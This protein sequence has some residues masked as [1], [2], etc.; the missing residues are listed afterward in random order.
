MSDPSPAPAALAC[1]SCRAPMTT[2]RLDGHYGTGVDL[3][4]CQICHGIWFDERESLRLT[5]GATLRL[6]QT[7][8]DGR[9]AKRRTLA[10]RLQCP[11]CDLRLL[12]THDRQRATPFRYW[13]CARAHGRFITFFDFLREKEFVRPLTA[14][15]IA[16]LRSQ[17]RS[18]NCSNC[19]GPI[20]LQTASA[21]SYCR[22]PLSMLD[23]VQVERMVAA[24]GEAEAKRVA[25]ERLGPVD[26]GLPLALLRERLHVERL[27]R[28]ADHKA[29]WGLWSPNGL[30]EAGIGAV[31]ELLRRK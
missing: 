9:G 24:L 25:A 8:H 15:Q 2:L 31:V 26:P 27:F 3:D 11:R 22:T 4:L 6:F 13:R 20:D 19:G 12:P 21:C 17:V 7:I 30:V 14:A 28:Q 29:D 23:F 5:P 18:V 1:A 16:E 10:D